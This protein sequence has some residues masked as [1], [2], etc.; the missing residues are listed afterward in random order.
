MALGNILNDLIIEPPVNRLRVYVYLKMEGTWLNLINWNEWTCVDLAV[1]LVLA[2]FMFDMAFLLKRPLFNSLVQ[3]EIFGWPCLL[4]YFYLNVASVTKWRVLDSIWL[5]KW[6]NLCVF[7]I[8]SVLFV[9]C[10]FCTKLCEIMFI[11]A[12]LLKRPLFNSRVQKEIF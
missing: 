8:G 6:M 2:G 3:K 9:A 10:G 11:M 7:G 1:L 4:I 12:T 5:I